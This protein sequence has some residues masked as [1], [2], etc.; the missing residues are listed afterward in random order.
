MEISR[1]KTNFSQK[2]AVV[3]LFVVLTFAVAGLTAMT[4]LSESFVVAQGQNSTRPITRPIHGTDPISI[5][6]KT[7]DG[8]TTT[9]NQ[10]ATTNATTTTPTTKSYV[11]GALTTNQTATTNA[12][13]VE[14]GTGDI[15]N[16]TESVQ[17]FVSLIPTDSNLTMIN[18][19]IVRGSGPITDTEG[20]WDALTSQSMT[21]YDRNVIL[22]EVKSLLA[23]AKPGFTQIQQDA[24]SKCITDE[25]NSLG[26]TPNY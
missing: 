26:P 9:T 21:A 3:A 8:E 11:I 17:N 2:V 22:T 16:W 10:T 7:V 1:L 23:A 25:T 5:C 6:F 15:Q 20:I 13:T 18:E 12:S 24:L 14:V 19:K 4:F